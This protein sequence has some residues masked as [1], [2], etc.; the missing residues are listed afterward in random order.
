MIETYPYNAGILCSKLAPLSSPASNTR[1]EWPFRARF[2]L[3][4]LADHVLSFWETSLTP[5]VPR[6][7]LNR[8]RHIRM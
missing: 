7:D 6:Q 3:L 2:A 8:Q 4:E 5:M 1:T